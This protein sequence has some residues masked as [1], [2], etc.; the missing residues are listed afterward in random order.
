MLQKIRDGRTDM[1]FD[2][3]SSGNDV[4]STDKN[5]RNL[6]TYCAYFGDV[7]AI[8]YLL[9]NGASLV[10]LGTNYDLN[11]AAFHGHWQL[12]QYLLEQGAD[13]NHRLVDSGETALHA[14]L[15]SPNR[16][17]N[18]L[19]VKLLLAYGAHT[20]HPLHIAMMES[21]HGSKGTSGMSKNLIGKEYV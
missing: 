1:V 9:T 11:G 15:S 13:P 19:I 17:A 8:K 4:N 16:Y 12:C 6:I 10:D 18:R 14:V 7:S 20:I 2:F 21:D 5:G 3:L